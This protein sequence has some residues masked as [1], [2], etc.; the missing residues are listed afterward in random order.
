MLSRRLL[1]AACAAAL[2][3]AACG[4]GDDPTTGAGDDV[5]R[6]TASAPSTT[7][8]AADDHDHAEDHDHGDDHPE[9]TEVARD[10]ADGGDHGD[11]DHDVGDGETAGAADH[12]GDDGHDHGP[13]VAG[14]AGDA[15]PAEAS[16]RIDVAIVD[17]AVVGGAERHRVPT[18]SV[19]LIEVALEAADE[20]HLHGYDH[21]VSG[22]A[23]DIVQIAFVASIPGVWE[24]ELEGAGLRVAEIEVS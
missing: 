9:P 12:H 3:T 16:E 13:A 1:A 21:L 17:G 6:T 15:D 22:E 20:V 2:L 24:V 10:D 18:G 11:D 19:V 5:A 23:G 14:V 4:D 8:E 7:A